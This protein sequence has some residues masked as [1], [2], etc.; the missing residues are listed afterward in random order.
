MSNDDIKPVIDNMLRLMGGAE[1]AF[2][3]FDAEHAQINERWEQ[4][5]EIIGRILRAHLFVE[6]YLTAYLQAKN[7]QLGSLDA[8]RVT[9]SQKIAL[10][11]NASIVITELIPGIR[12]LNAVRNR[13]AHTLKPS[14]D[15]DD[16][17]VFRQ[18]Q[19]FQAMRKEGAKRFPRPLAVEPLELL[20]E[21]AKYVGL[22]LQADVSETGRAMRE[23]FKQ[24]SDEF[25]ER[26][27]RQTPQ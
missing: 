27:A 1:K 9:F 19:L 16:A 24:A 4:N 20:E 6:H 13:I 17:N 8:A 26:V 15:A 18:A 5:T 12:K 21:F 14:V 25:Q 10:L 2:K 7:P 11:E 3:E 23:A 22:T